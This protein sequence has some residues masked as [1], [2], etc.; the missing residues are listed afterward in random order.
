MLYI[1]IYMSFF[2]SFFKHL[3]LE[4]LDVYFEFFEVLVFEYFFC[5]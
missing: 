1:F 3:F 4:S 2:Y 5:F